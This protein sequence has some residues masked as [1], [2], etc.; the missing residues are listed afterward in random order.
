MSGQLIAN[1]QAITHVRAEVAAAVEDIHRA[2][3]RL[4]RVLD[5]RLPELRLQEGQRDA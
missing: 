5:E 4:Q 3:E 1:D 2:L